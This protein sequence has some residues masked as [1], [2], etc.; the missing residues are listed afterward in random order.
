MTIEISYERHLAQENCFL[1]LETQHLYICC[2]KNY[3]QRLS[4]YYNGIVVQIWLNT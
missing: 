2:F 1:L 4:L 3:F